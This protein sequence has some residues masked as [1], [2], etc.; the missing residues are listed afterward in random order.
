M[1]NIK[2]EIIL[3]TTNKVKFKIKYDADSNKIEYILRYD[4]Y[5]NVIE[6]IRYD[7][8]KEYPI[9]RI[10][11]HFNEGKI[12]EKVFYDFKLQ[13][14]I[15]PVLD[16]IITY[17]YDLLIAKNFYIKD[18]VFEKH[19]YIYDENN[20]LIEISIENKNKTITL[21]KKYYEKDLIKKWDSFRDGI[22][23]SSSIYSYDKDS[24]LLKVDCFNK[25][26][27]T[28]SV[29]Y[30]YNSKNKLLQQISNLKSIDVIYVFF[31]Y[32]FSFVHTFFLF[33]K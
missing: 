24:N 33:L 19:N 4:I 9:K 7:I 28:D 32:F 14:K 17:E 31:I 16:E 15:I 29:T 1:F 11:S 8:I 30:I 3:K 13:N 26:E 25:D 27:L 12:V 2:D 21:L 20:N 23:G 22:L 18:K 10:K 6:E 5:S